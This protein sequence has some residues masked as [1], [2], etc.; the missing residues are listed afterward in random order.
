MAFTGTITGNLGRD[1][2]LRALPS[3]QM[4]TNFS[5]AVRQP[6]VKGED[7]PALWVKVELWG[8]TAEYAADYL[9]KGD[10]VYCTGEVKQEEFTRRDG[11]AGQA[12]VLKN[13]RVEK[14]SSREGS[15]PTPAPVAAAKPAAQPAAS[16]IEDDGIPF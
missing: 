2:E 16:Y 12:I 4:V 5:V 1:P 14:F 6:K 11:T 3:G 13:A 15:A 7:P 9:K 8:K 10:S